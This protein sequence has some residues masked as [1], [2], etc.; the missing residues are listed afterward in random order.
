MIDVKKPAVAVYAT[1]KFKDMEEV[2]GG[3]RHDKEGRHL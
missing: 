1:N 2:F 3:I